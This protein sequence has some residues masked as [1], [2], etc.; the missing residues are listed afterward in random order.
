MCACVSVSVCEGVRVCVCKCEAYTNFK[1]NRH[2]VN[3]LYICVHIQVCGL[4]RP[5]GSLVVAGGS[6]G[7]AAY[8]QGKL[9]SS[10]NRK[11]VLCEIAVN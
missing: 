6:L 7:L 4:K 2:P 1:R 8:L 11:L 3:C 9:V 10:G 5:Q